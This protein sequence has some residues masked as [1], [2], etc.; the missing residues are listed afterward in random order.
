M[1]VMKKVLLLSDFNKK[2]PKKL[3]KR[4][5]D[6]YFSDLIESPSGIMQPDKKRTHK[7][8]RTECKRVIREEL[9][10]DQD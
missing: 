3:M 9:N 6:P 5:R 10:T 8:S 4:K 2:K 7:K 1:C